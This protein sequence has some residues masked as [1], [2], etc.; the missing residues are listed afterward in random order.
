MLIKFKRKD[1]LTVIE[2]NREK[3]RI[4]FENEKRR[5]LNEIEA[6]LNSKVNF[7]SQLRDGDADFSSFSCSC[8]LNKP[9]SFLYEY[10]VIIKFLQNSSEEYVKF[11]P[12]DYQRFILNEW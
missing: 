4:N 2:T 3:H 8:S 1:V 7:I 6:W 11:T 10:D 9:K 12:T 5:Y